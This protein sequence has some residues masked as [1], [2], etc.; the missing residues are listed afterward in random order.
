MTEH[1][2]TLRAG[3]RSMTDEAIERAALNNARWCDAVCAAHGHP[4]QFET[5]LWRNRHAAPRF[6]PNAVTLSRGDTASQQQRVAELVD[7]G[8]AGGWGVKDSFCT[9][10]LGSLGFHV[11]FEARWISRK[12][13][14]PSREPHEAS[15]A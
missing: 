12:P 3:S 8:L 4:G 14:A 9:L 11:L 10:D 5:G 15:G 13:A 1:E 6:Y 7:A 2:D